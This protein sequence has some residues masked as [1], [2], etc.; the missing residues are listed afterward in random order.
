M[1]PPGLIPNPPPTEKPVPVSAAEE[2]KVLADNKE[3]TGIKDTAGYLVQLHKEGKVGKAAAIAQQLKR[4]SLTILE[5]SN[6]TVEVEAAKGRWPWMNGSGWPYCPDVDCDGEVTILDLVKI[7]TLLETETTFLQLM[8]VAGAFGETVNYKGIRAEGNYFG[9]DLKEGDKV[10]YF[11]KPIVLTAKAIGLSR[12]G[13]TSAPQQANAAMVVP[14][15]KRI[16][17]INAI[18]VDSGHASANSI[19]RA[20]LAV[21]GNVGL[22]GPIAAAAK[23]GL[24]W[25]MK[26]DRFQV[27]GPT[28]LELVTFLANHPDLSK[29]QNGVIESNNVSNGQRRVAIKNL[30]TGEGTSSVV[31]TFF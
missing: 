5:R 26:W 17:I 16:R 29:N 31:A 27:E 2:P 1:I 20:A 21:P 7:S 3:I 4:L 19:E 8:E 22:P 11:P 13:G 23:D 14:A 30:D 6:L 18:I 12:T 9:K 28:Q 10:L 15:T 25:P 24:F